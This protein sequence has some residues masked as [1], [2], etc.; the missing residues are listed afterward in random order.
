MDE[1][2]EHN[3]GIA[4]ARVGAAAAA[5]AAAEGKKVVGMVK[6]EY[7]LAV[8]KAVDKLTVYGKVMTRQERMGMD[9]RQQWQC[10]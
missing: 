3:G 6:R 1:G 5:A 9:K 10:R 8:D 4:M 2:S 7:I